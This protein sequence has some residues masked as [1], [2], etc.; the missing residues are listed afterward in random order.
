MFDRQH[1]PRPAA[2]DAYSWPPAINTGGGTL[3]SPPH[4]KGPRYH[5]VSNTGRQRPRP[6]RSR[7]KA[8]NG[9]PGAYSCVSSL[10]IVNAYIFV[11]I[12]VYAYICVSMCI[13]AYL[14]YAPASVT[15][16]RICTASARCRVFTCATCVALCRFV[17][18]CVTWCG[19]LCRFVS[20]CVAHCVLLCRLVWRIVPFCAASCPG[21]RR[22]RLHEAGLGFRV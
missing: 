3:R 10:S 5:S 13:Y 9:A 21:A 22:A 7:D 14:C 6:S 15:L 20:L 12:R 19:T 4:R 17:P 2:T 18:F 1:P 11:S 8:G 16:W